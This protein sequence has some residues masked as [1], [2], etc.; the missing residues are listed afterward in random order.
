LNNEFDY[1]RD[2]IL[3]NK[4]LML[5]KELNKLTNPEMLKQVGDSKKKIYSLEDITL[6]IQSNVTYPE[7]YSGYDQ[8]PKV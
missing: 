6:N 5:K 4:Q 2:L 7:N 8:T 1:I 3:L